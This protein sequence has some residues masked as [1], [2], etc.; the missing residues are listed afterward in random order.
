MHIVI[1]KCGIV[2]ND[3]IYLF[4]C[5]REDEFPPI[6]VLLVFS[7]STLLSPLVIL[8]FCNEASPNSF[9]CFFLSLIWQDNKRL[10]VKDGAGLQHNIFLLLTDVME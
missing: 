9:S 4:L 3:V 2:S 1:S 5:F 10:Q 8:I 7:L 6:L